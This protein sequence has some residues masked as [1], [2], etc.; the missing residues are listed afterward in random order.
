MWYWRGLHL[1]NTN[2]LSTFFPDCMIDRMA[3]NEYKRVNSEA[4]LV[5]L[6]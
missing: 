1:N 4:L 6:P 5:F 2:L 3:V